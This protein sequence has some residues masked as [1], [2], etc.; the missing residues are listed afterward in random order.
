MVAHRSFYKTIFI[1]FLIIFPQ[2]AE[3][4]SDIYYVTEN[5]AG[6]K[7]GLSIENAWSISDFNNS[8]RWSSEDNPSLIDPGDTIYLSGTFTKS[9]I[10]RGSGTEN[11]M[12]V[13][14]GTDANVLTNILE[15]PRIFDIY[16]VRYL[17]LKNITING[18]D[19]NMTCPDNRAAI[20]IREWGSPTGFIT[21]QNSNI[22][23]SSAGI[24]LQGNVTNI[25]IYN[26][27][28]ENMSYYGV[29][30]FA[31]SYDSDNLWYYDDCP[32]FITV[33]GSRNR[34]NV[35]KNIGKE[36]DGEI[37]PGQTIGT[38][39]TDIVFS[40]N[41]VYATLADVGTGIYMNGAKR[42]LVENNVIHGLQAKKH[43][44]YIDFKCDPLT[45]PDG[46]LLFSED[47]IIRFNKIY[48][49]YVG[50]N[51]Y[52]QP[53]YAITISG[54]GKSR[55]IYGNYI[56]GAGI[57]LNWNWQE[58][59]EGIGGEGYFV[60]A[61][62][63]N[64]STTTGGITISGM[65][66]NTDTFKDWYIFNN[67]IFRV[68]QDHENVYAP[69]YQYGIA[70]VDSA[71]NVVMNMNIMNN[72]VVD[73]RPSSNEAINFRFPYSTNIKFDYNHHWCTGKTPQNKF[74]GSTC[75]P[76]SW[77]S[78]RLPTSYGTHDSAG[79]PGFSDA[80]N[81]NFS[82]TANS[83]CKDSGENLSARYPVLPAVKIQGT[84]YIL[85]SS[86]ALDPS[87]NWTLDSPVVVI[88]DQNKYGNWEK[89]A[90]VFVN[91]SLTPPV[92]L[93]VQ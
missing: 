50:P 74:I 76:C 77:N 35:F 21:V 7:N 64:G 67:T 41:H 38:L 43:R 72:V 63:I 30:L 6:S 36:L 42:V 71:A 20:Y 24:F 48:D 54:R 45:S 26:N 69:S 44:P 56:K 53:G 90:Y 82:L 62:I 23:N 37:V 58:E 73:T 32:S 86:D 19:S 46:Q 1:L 93:K 9:F 16:N 70:A 11:N 34:G 27:I 51:I 55:F 80:A 91:K 75:D 12:I 18:Q 60:W 4:S 88:A 25:N 89:G 57:D 83:P 33:G 61:N 40:Y 78:D 65:S 10:P 79:D 14:D 52:A 49:V 81:D 85:T 15:Y 31:D 22:K 28:I 2:L 3:A 66:R 92:N 29:A 68:I 5:G 8:S 13:I 39:G 84:S 47:I 17:T 59:N 87:T